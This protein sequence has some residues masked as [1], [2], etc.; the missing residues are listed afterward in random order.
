MRTPVPVLLS[1]VCCLAAGSASAAPIMYVH[2][3]D[4]VLGTVDVESGATTTIGS[5]GVVMTDIAFDP[6]GNLF[7]ISFTGLYAID[8]LTASAAFIGNHSIAGGNALVFGADGTLYGA[9]N[10][11]T[12]LYTLD[13]ATGA[14]TSVGNMGFLSGGDLAFNMGSFYLASSSAQLVSVNPA[15]GAG[16]LIGDF[17]VSNVFGLATGDDG[18]LYG[19]AGTSIFTVNPLTGAG[20]N[21][22]SFAGQGLS[23]AFGQ[24]FLSEAGA[25]AAVPDGA[26]SLLLAAMGLGAVLL[27]QRRLI[28]S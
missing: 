6:L 9:G 26:S 28:H 25:L 14:S 1:L 5:M 19:V 21:P 15:T 10:S 7:G 3:Q 23:N 12:N 24:S 11:S 16:T 2:D 4:G 17:G 20:V 22:V 13:A 27:A 8:H 18:V